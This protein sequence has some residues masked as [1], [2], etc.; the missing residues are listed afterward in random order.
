[1]LSLAYKLAKP[2]LFS[3][4]PERAHTLT[5]SMV[6]RFGGLVPH[7]RPDPSLAVVLLDVVIGYGAHD[8]PAGHLAEVLKVYGVANGPTTIASVT[9]TEADPQI[10]SLQM[11]KLEA[12]GVRVAPTNADAAAW[13]LSAI[14]S[15]D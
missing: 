8:D 14:R 3:L 7:H 11:A 15:N 9:G 13:A 12:A 5:L 4:D 6:E 1:M 10:R 2:L